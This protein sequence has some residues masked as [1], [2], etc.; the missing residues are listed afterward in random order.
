[1]RNS[2]GCIVSR[3]LF[4]RLRFFECKQRTQAGPLE[5]VNED[6]MNC[7]GIFGA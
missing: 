5:R 1:M 6:P 4:L 2:I 7:G 3:P